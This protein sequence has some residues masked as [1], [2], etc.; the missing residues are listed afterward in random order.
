[1]KHLN[2]LVEHRIRGQIDYWEA[3]RRNPGREIPLGQRFCRRRHFRRR[4]FRHGLSGLRSRV[5]PRGGHQDRHPL[6]SGGVVEA[7]LGARRDERRR[8]WW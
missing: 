1:M 8:Y 5:E 4:R 7:A 3:Q 6:S 2:S